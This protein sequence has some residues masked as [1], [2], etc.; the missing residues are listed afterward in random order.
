MENWWG[1]VRRQRR[2]LHRGLTLRPPPCLTTISHSAPL[3][4]LIPEDVS[5]VGPG[6]GRHTWGSRAHSAQ[7]FLYRNPQNWLFP[8]WGAPWDTLISKQQRLPAPSPAMSDTVLSRTSFR[9]SVLRFIDFWNLVCFGG[10]C[11][12]KTSLGEK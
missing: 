3:S 2:R 4:S 12:W 6:T 11:F 8:G 10:P 5:W 9:T 7:G 1:A